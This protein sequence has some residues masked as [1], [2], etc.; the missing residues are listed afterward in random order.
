MI[1]YFGSGFLSVILGFFLGGNHFIYIYFVLLVFFILF[2]D[3]FNF[4]KPPFSF[5]LLF[6]S[7]LVPGFVYFF[8]SEFFFEHLI[9]FSL[10][11]FCLV[12]C[13]FSFVK[14]YELFYSTLG[15]SIGFCFLIIVLSIFSDNVVFSLILASFD[16][17]FVSLWLVFLIFVISKR[18]NFNSLYFYIS[19]A[20]V[21]Y[22]GVMLES[23]SFLVLSLLVFLIHIFKNNF[24]LAIL[25]V[26]I[27]IFSLF[28][29]NIDFTFL[30][31]YFYTLSSSFSGVYD[32][33]HLNEDFRRVFL[34]TLGIESIVNNFP[35]GSGFGPKNY[36]FL[37]KGTSSIFS[38]HADLRLGYPHNYIISII[39]QIGVLAIPWLLVIFSVCFRSFS[40]FSIISILF[41]ALI[42]NEYIG[43]PVIWVAIGLFFNFDFLRK[44]NAKSNY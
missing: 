18:F 35:F 43:S 13:Y 9:Y 39:S 28:F 11:I 2:I 37:V 6:F 17:N 40:S 26:L 25:F 27:F 42:F 31:N 34:F 15:V 5:F 4:I 23:R 19:L 29:L 24:I 10:Y 36:I 33:S 16:T 32:V 1:K 44:F 21:L 7:I 14:P 3:R 41:F 12:L 30:Y 20:V 8:I 38:D 22:S